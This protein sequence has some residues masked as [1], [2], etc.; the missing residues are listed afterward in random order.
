MF[1]SASHVTT[2]RVRA[3][4]GDIGPV[5]DLLLDDRSWVVRYLLVDAGCWL[6]RVVFER[7]QSSTT[8][9]NKRILFQL[10]FVGFTRVGTNALQTLKDNI[11]RY[12]FLREQVTTPS[13]FGNYD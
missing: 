11:P 13:R 3:A 1:N 5:M 8:S 12:Q 10:E 7:L 4:D 6:G 9:S 2:A